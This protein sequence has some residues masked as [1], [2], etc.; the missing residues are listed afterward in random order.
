MKSR[1]RLSRARS[2]G[3]LWFG[4]MLGPVTIAVGAIVAAVLVPV[5]ATAAAATA[6]AAP[7]API[8]VSGTVL[9]ARVLA[10]AKGASVAIPSGLHKI[11]GARVSVTFSSGA[12]V[13]AVTN[14]AG[15]F[16]VARPAGTSAKAEATVRVS[17]PGFGS[18]RET[19]VPAALPHHNYPIL[20]VLLG[21]RS[22]SQAYPRNPVITHHPGQGATRGTPVAKRGRAKGIASPAAAG[23][24]SNYF[25]N[26]EPP[27]F[28]RVYNVGTGTIQ[29]YDFE[30]YVENVLPNEWIASWPAASLSAGAMAVKTYGWY[31]VNNWRGGSL[32]GTCYDVS[33]G[34][35]GGTCDVDYQCF[36]PGSA[37]A[38]TDSA[39]SGT[40]NDV[41]LRNGA[42]FEATYNSGYSSDTCGEVDG[43]PA[44]G[45]EMSQWGT[46]ACAND[47]DGWESIFTTYYFPGITFPKTDSSALG[48]GVNPSNDNQ[49]VFWRG[50]NGDMYQAYYNG[51]WNGPQDMCTKYSW[52]CSGIDS[53]PAV[54][55]ANNGD[56]YVFWVGSGGDIYE[57]NYSDANGWGSALDMTSSK[58][59]NTASSGLGVAVNPSNN[60]QYV[61]WRGSNG[62]MYQAYYNGSWNGPQDMCTNYS[63]GCS[64]IESAPG[65]AVANDGNEYVFWR[66]SGGDVYEADYSDANGWSSSLDLSSKLGAPA[67]AAATSGPGVAVNP[68]NDH[69]YVFWRGD[70]GDV[71][72]AYFNGSWNGPQDM[73]TNY[74]WGSNIASAPAAAVA[75]DGNEWVFWRGTTGDIYEA[76]Y[77][78]ASGWAPSINMTTSKGWTE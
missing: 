60:N 62:D 70:N 20:S 26:S 33:G 16:T 48:V 30:Y 59:W 75:N 21:A 13:H 14:R 77:S 24:C 44:S 2:S 74:S 27:A 7:T 54:A 12:T 29:T 76:Y 11:A 61:F 32:D 36:I 38:A 6:V 22:Q 56:E 64:G 52:G 46:D 34:T 63:W 51:S 72:Q 18:W 1:D 41:A 50:S 31:W 10:T 8:A 45:T 17:A 73:Y 57:A 69:Q 67:A 65:V 71:Y 47:G 43:S 58:G 23:G 39:V 5:S 37:T 25:S 28:I 78:D 19:G 53:A 55:V 15:A 42:V 49:Y 35:S 68:S 9:N 4:R 40:W 66:G 3:A